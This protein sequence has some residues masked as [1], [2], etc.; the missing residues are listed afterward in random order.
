VLWYDRP[1]YVTPGLDA[2]ADRFDLVL[3][4]HG[5]W[6]DT[7]RPDAFSL[8]V[9]LERY[10][11]FEAGPDVERVPAFFGALDPRLGHRSHDRLES[12]LRAAVTHGLRAF[13]DS[14]TDELAGDPAAFPTDFGAARSG[15]LPSRKR[16][17]TYR[18]HPVWVAMPPFS[19]ASLHTRTLE[20][21]ASGARVVVPHA[22]DVEGELKHRVFEANADA[23][24]AL[25]AAL[26]AVGDGA[27]F[28]VLRELYL[29]AS[30]GQW[31][32][33]LARQLSRDVDPR[34]ARATTLV[35]ADVDAASAPALAQSVLAQRE[36]PAHVVASV[37]NG[38]AAAVGVGLSPLERS[39][40]RVDVV[41]GDAGSAVARATTPFVA[42]APP[43]DG[44]DQ[45]LDLHVVQA[46][47]GAA[48]AAIGD[49]ALVRTDAV[50][51]GDVTLTQRDGAY[52]WDA[53]ATITSA[54]PA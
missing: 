43:G 5:P 12:V 6:A 38:A 33:R 22:I 37:T 41:E 20:Q 47:T 21:L 26:D 42:I 4:D 27:Q 28:V 48:L 3:T 36:R 24:H 1:P 54:V 34:A 35:L 9:Q 40:I 39:S 31:L 11:A 46:C 23:D 14:S 30:T 8:G 18:R 49:R 51:R 2:L 53:P 44:G 25:Y 15:Y 7:D 19:P 32:S 50:R 16:P 17:A 45:L 13:D 29:R 52:R 10:G